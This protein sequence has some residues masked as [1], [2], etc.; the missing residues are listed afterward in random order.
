MP[1]R[2]GRFALLPH[3]KA[4]DSVTGAPPK[5]AIAPSGPWIP[6]SVIPPP[7]VGRRRHGGRIRI[8]YRHAGRRGLDLSA[9]LVKR[10]LLVEQGLQVVRTEINISSPHARA[11]S[12]PPP[13]GRAALPPRAGQTQHASCPGTATMPALTSRTHARG[14]GGSCRLQDGATAGAASAVLM[15]AAART[16]VTS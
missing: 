5:Q 7:P 1:G 4:P 2:L 16:E 13:Q 8:Q 11:S 14:S 15:D 12:C 9:E 3:T 6:A 10:G